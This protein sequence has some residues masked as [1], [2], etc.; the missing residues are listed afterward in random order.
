M[1]RLH[2]SEKN[3]R[4]SPTRA[5][6]KIFTSPNSVSRIS[7]P[8]DSMALPRGQG[9]PAVLLIFDRGRSGD[10]RPLATARATSGVTGHDVPRLT[11][12]DRTGRCCRDRPGCRRG[13]EWTRPAR[14]IT[15]S[16]R[17]CRSNNMPNTVIIFR[18]PGIGHEPAGVRRCIAWRAEPRTTPG[19]QPDYS[20]L[21]ITTALA[22]RTVF[23]LALRRSRSA[24]FEKDCFGKACSRHGSGTRF[25]PPPSNV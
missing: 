1:R 13:P 9:A 15:G 22:M 12:C 16:F 3:P 17:P 5:G 4:L 11:L 2:T 21:A 18:G 14:F 8:F 6:T 19:G 24:L 7:I 20:T 25:Q 23:G 10:K